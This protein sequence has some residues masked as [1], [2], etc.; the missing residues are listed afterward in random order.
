MSEKE[1][2]EMST[3]VLIARI[4]GFERLMD[5]RDRRYEE[6]SVQSTKSVELAL[7][8]QKSLSEQ[9]FANAEKAIAKADTATEKRFD[10]VNEF[11]AQLS[12]Q[13]STFLPRNEY[14]VQHK[15]MEEKIDAVEANLTARIEQ[16]NKASLD[17]IADLKD[18]RTLTK[19]RGEGISATVAYMIA[20]VGVVCT[21]IGLILGIV[22]RPVA[23]QSPV[24]VAV[25]ESVNK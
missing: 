18:S 4:D 11:R 6:R 16:N 10:A 7:T 23:A 5:E 17:S 19:G 12:D 24:P 3:G 21:I 13:T 8:A 25:H 20:G 1:N 15:S 2:S 9:A 14:T 22:F